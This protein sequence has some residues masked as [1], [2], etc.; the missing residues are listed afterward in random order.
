MRKQPLAKSV[1]AESIERRIL[2]IRGQKVML[3]S[4][5]AQFYGVS[6]EKKQGVTN[7]DHQEGKVCGSGDSD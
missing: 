5:L 1:P 3:N 4:D 2:L 6:T 7:C